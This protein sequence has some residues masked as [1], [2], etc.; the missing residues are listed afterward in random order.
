MAASQ[1]YPLLAVGSQIP[2]RRVVFSAIL[3]VPTAGQAVQF[4]AFRIPYGAIVTVRKLPANTGQVFVGRHRNLAAA[5][6]ASGDVIILGFAGATGDY[7]IEIDS[8]NVLSQWFAD[9]AVNGEGVQILV[10]INT[11]RNFGFSQ[12][13]AL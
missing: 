2:N 10:E 6:A 12:Y 5:A 13:G 7:P 4:P 3:R 1:K 8:D 9:A 11:F